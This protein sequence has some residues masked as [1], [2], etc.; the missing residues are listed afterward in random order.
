[1]GW[2]K[3]LIVRVKGICHR[4]FGPLLFQ[5]LKHQIIALQY[6]Q[7]K[8]VFNIKGQVCKI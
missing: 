8:F 2:Q 7:S 1:M 3:E 6:A 4:L 5:N